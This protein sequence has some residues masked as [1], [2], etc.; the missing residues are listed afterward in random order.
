MIASVSVEKHQGT[1]Q[2]SHE[3]AA[4]AWSTYI[5]G[6]FSGYPPS[7]VTVNGKGI[8]TWS[9]APRTWLVARIPVPCL[10]QDLAGHVQ[11]CGGFILWAKGAVRVFKQSGDMV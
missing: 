8:Q 6:L 3:E 11:P 10:L 1:N 4:Q 9:W 7:V 2:G 5:P